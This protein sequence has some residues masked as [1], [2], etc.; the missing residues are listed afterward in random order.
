MDFLNRAYSQLHGTYRSMTPGSRLTAGMLAVVVLLSVI[1]LFTQQVA[2]PDADLMHGVPVAASQLPVMEAAFAKANLKGAEV[3]GTSIRVPRGQEAVYMAALAD[4]KALPPNFG[5]AMNEAISASNPF[6]GR[7]QREDRMKNALQAELSLIIRSMAG[8]ENASVLY[9]VDNKAGFNREK[10][11]TAAVVVKPSGSGTL[12]EARVVAIRH[13]VAG[14]AIAGLKP[15]NVTVSDLNGRT[16]YRNLD[17]A[18]GVGEENLYVSLK[19]IYEQDLKA[20]ILNALCFIPN[21]AV[22]PSVDLDHERITRIKQ[23]KRSTSGGDRQPGGNPSG[24]EAKNGRASSGQ[25]PNTAT[26]LNALLGGSRSEDT[27][28]QANQPGPASDE[29]VEKESVGLT[30]TRASV[31]VSVPI[32]YFKKVWQERNPA[33]AG[34]SAKTPDPAALD[35]IRIE[36]SAKIQRHV[37]QLLPSTESVAK[38]AELVT[39]TTFQDIPI[40]EPPPPGFEQE[41]LSWLRQSW[42]TVGMIGLS[43]V[44]LLVLRSMFRHG[45]A[46][47]PTPSMSQN[48]DI[49][50]Q[51]DLGRPADVPA[52]HAR[53]FYTPS[54]SAREELSQWVEDDPDAAANVLRSWIGDAN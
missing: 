50:D 35:Q 5:A 19:R 21:V 38:A 6:E 11:I 15:E 10:V 20:K 13:F 23:T 41:V 9:D 27:G 52:P 43:L 36:E 14:G 18:D 49:A 24:L 34:G 25:L 37:A 26:V 31:S 3:H 1:Y 2:S 12:D 48:A 53:R 42:R 33:V 4:A 47:A 44:G 40:V 16:W 46:V 45:P 54:P 51:V 30:P 32:S 17:D 22:E 29:Q 7:Q 39:V 8:I 28:T